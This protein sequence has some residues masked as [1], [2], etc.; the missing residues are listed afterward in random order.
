MRILFVESD[1]DLRAFFGSKIKEEFKG[2]VD[3]VAT[4]KEAIKFLR[5]ERP[6]DVIISDYFLTK[7]SGTDLLQFKIKHNITGSFI[8]FYTA[9]GEINC[10]R[11]EYLLVNKLSFR[12]L[13][14]EIRRAKNVY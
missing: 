13:C 5:F 3:L 10:P 4:G 8:F 9:I 2:I 1:Q 7:G 11:E 14:E 6:Y 12:F